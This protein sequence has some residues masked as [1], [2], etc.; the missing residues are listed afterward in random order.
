[1][2]R[3]ALAAVVIA[4]VTGGTAT[5]TW[6]EIIPEFRPY[7]GVFLPT[8]DQRDALGDAVLVGGQL[9]VE[10]AERVH[11]LGTF[12]YVPTK[13]KARLLRWD[14]DIYQYDVGLETFR[15]Y[16][17]SG[18]WEFRPFVGA[19][20]GART[21]DPQVGDAETNVAGYG[22]LG[23]EFQLGNLA[24]RVEGRDYVTRFKG[25][26]GDQPARTRNDVMTMLGVVVHW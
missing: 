8:G 17:M 25:L 20:V 14:V 18:E 24:V 7:L 6:G 19:G 15:S 22:A 16:L 10:I 3:L 2:R 26:A 21:Y 11:L 5:L 23:A 1:M 13:D 9:G 4:A 12:G